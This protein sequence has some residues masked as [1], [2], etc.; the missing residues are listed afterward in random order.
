MLRKYYNC[1]NSVTNVQ[2]GSKSAI[3]KSGDQKVHTKNWKATIMSIIAIHTT[4]NPRVCACELEAGTE[5]YKTSWALL[6]AQASWEIIFRCLT[7][8]KS[9]DKNII[10]QYN[11]IVQKNRVLKRR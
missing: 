9:I 8:K 1:N 6:Y 11:I 2:S 10:L 5:R 4:H 7:S 3:V